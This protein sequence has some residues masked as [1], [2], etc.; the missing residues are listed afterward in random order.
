MA[1]ATAARIRRHLDLPTTVITNTESI[2]PGIAS[3]DKL[4]AIS[5]DTSNNRDASIWINKG[6][7]QAYDLTPYDETLLLDTDFMVNSNQLLKTFETYDDFCCH[8]S[9]SFLMNPG[10]A[11]E[12]LSPLSF[13]TLWATVVTFR[14]TD[15]THDIFQAWEMVQ[16]N[17]DHYAN[18]HGFVNGFYRNDYALTLALRIANG[19]STNPRDTIPWPLLHAGKNTQ[20]ERLDDTSYRVGYDNWTRGKI[21][22]EHGIIRDTDFHVMSKDLFMELV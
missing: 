19:H 17:Y 3:F 16:K 10:V 12:A 21:R 4:I 6:R 8:N 22:K 2:G 13:D 1:S 14:K 20:L 9:T 11:Q 18:L 5:P 7:F 15:R